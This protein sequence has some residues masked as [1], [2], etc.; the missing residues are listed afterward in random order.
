MRPSGLRFPRRFPY[1]LLGAIGL[2]NIGVRM[3]GRGSGRARERRNGLVVL[4]WLVVPIATVIALKSI[5]Y[6]T[7]RQLYFVYPALVLMAMAGAQALWD[8]S[9]RAG[10]GKMLLRG[11]T[12]AGIAA[13][14]LHVG[15]FMVA[16]HPF[17]DVYFN[18]LAGRDM[19]DIKQR[20]E[21]DYWGLWYRQ[22]LECV[23][24]RDGRPQ[25]TVLAAN[26]PARYNPA[27]LPAADRTRLSFVREQKDADYFVS[28]FRWH[29]AEYDIDASREVCNVMV[30]NA[31][32]NVAY[33][34]R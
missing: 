34:L 29:K 4:L 3:L 26:N 23:L 32:I 18:R 24:A 25:I 33:R 10:R 21:L 12:V 13:A 6:D 11:L 20:F 30:G 14:L 16:N 9:G 1:L 17:Q 5:L 7:W 19:A 28:N 15:T 22:I 8:A 2:G 31:R 27:I